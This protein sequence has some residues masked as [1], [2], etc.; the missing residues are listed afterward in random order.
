MIHNKVAHNLCR[1]WKPIVIRQCLSNLL[2]LIE[3][4]TLK[5][6]YKCMYTSVCWRATSLAAPDLCYYHYS[7]GNNFVL[8]PFISSGILLTLVKLY[9]KG[10]SFHPYT[11]IGFIPPR[12]QCGTRYGSFD[13]IITLL[14]PIFPSHILKHLRIIFWW[15]D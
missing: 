7:Y 3:K 1:I 15:L 13:T 12:F 10:V 14:L 2:S 6:V 9:V 11:V 5:L 4:A 8:P